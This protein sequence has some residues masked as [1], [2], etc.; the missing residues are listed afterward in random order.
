M[1]CT[2]VETPVGHIKLCV[3]Q[4]KLVRSSFATK[5]HDYAGCRTATADSDDIRILSIARQQLKEYFLHLRKDF[6]I[7]LSISGSPFRF[8]VYEQL[9]AI[10]YGETKS[11]GNIA[12]AAGSPKAA[13]AV[14]TA[15]AKNML[16]IFIPC[17]R[18]VAAHGIGEFSGGLHIKEWLL[19]HEITHDLEYPRL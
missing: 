15:C 17:H 1:V 12:A 9:M 14:G 3:S 4:G 16:V 8:R 18:V 11:Y 6:D 2:Y 5:P 19:K 7:P 13:R 10:P